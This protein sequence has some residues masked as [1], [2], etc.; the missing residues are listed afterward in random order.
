VKTERI[1]FTNGCFDILHEGH[2]RLLEY[3]ASLGDV[4]V[5]INSD[6]SVSRIKGP[7]RPVNGQAARKY[8]LSSIIFVK[9][10]YIFEE[11][12]PLNLIRRIRP[13]II[14]KGGD[15]LASEVV[16]SD[17]ARIE[18][19]PLVKDISTTKLLGQMNQV[20]MKGPG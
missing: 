20:G 17:L 15:Y 12:T 10:V 18:I 19:F 3:C 14:V 11:D 2:V 16:G 13:D 1:V 6:E 5:G 9:Q 7:G 8:L 4:I